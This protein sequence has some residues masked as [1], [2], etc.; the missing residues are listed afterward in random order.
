MKKKSIRKGEGVGRK[1][2]GERIYIFLIFSSFRFFFRFM[3][4]GLQVFVGTVGKVDL[5]Y[6]SYAW[7]PKSWSFV[8]LHEVENFP[9]CVISSLKAI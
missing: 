1:R 5:R 3:K 2:M 8:K 7:T 4:I 6:K 9:T